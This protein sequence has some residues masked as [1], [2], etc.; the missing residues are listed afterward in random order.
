MADSN[1]TGAKIASYRTKRKNNGSGIN[2]TSARIETGWEVVQ[3]GAVASGIKAVTF[4]TPFTNVPIILTNCG[5][6]QASGTQALGNGA[7]SIQGKITTKHEGDTVNGFNLRFYADASWSSG[8]NVYL[9]WIA[10]G[11]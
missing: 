11:T 3:P 7:N 9:T 6:D 4:Q 8:N 5:G 1:V 10:I 2:E